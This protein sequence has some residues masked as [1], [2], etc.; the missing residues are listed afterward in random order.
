MVSIVQRCSVSKK[1]N[2]RE[3][4]S[5]I[6]DGEN[7]CFDEL[8][9]RYREKLFFYLRHLVGNKEE[10]EDLLQ[11]VFVKAYEKFATF[12]A[13]RAFSSW[14]YRIAHNEA[15]NHLKRKSR[16]TFLS[17][18]D[19]VSSKDQIESSSKERSPYDD[20][21]RK[22]VRNEVR[23]SMAKLPEKY[24]EVLILRFYLDHSYEEIGAIIRKPTN[25]VGTLLARAKSRLLREINCE[26]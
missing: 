19:I 18:E 16:K 9:E 7:V 22:E 17:W 6:R 13:R 21:V 25:T 26:T 24:R 23:E 12:D 15:V 8:F 10:A 20:W 1:T 11:N 14:I 2:D 4:I 5:H 3:I